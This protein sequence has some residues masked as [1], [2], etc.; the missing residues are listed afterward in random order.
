MI[1]LEEIKSMNK[2]GKENKINEIVGKNNDTRHTF[3][4]HNMQ[5]NN[6][7]PKIRAEKCCGREF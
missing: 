3:K 4:Y 7:L 2:K 5:K 1:T 6:Y